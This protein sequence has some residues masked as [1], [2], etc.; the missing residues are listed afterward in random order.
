MLGSVKQGV[1]FFFLLLF[2]LA[3]ILTVI[4]LPEFRGAA[5]TGEITQSVHH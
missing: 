5:G 2:F 4:F 1:D 3:K